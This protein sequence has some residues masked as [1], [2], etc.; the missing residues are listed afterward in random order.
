MKTED[1]KSTMKKTLCSMLC[2]LVIL[3]M[4]GCKPTD[5]SDANY[6]A[7]KSAIE[8][9]DSL[10]DFEISYSDA[11]ERVGRILLRMEIGTTKDD[12]LL[13]QMTTLKY[14]LQ[15]QAYGELKGISPNDTEIIEQ[16]NEVAETIGESKIK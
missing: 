9:V 1:L 3:C 12:L 8:V 16:R 4:V 14:K 2:L 10:M 7:A 15:A 6:E 11:E 5:I 13:A